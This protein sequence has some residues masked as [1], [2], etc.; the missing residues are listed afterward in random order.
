M[1]SDES[2]GRKHDP[3][4]N[5]PNLSPAQ[6]KDR[7]IGM[8]V[9]GVAF[10]VAIGISWYSAKTIEEPKSDKPNVVPARLTK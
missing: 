4:E 10:A 1:S 5:Q 7:L 9:V 6:K 3:R 2:P 8:L